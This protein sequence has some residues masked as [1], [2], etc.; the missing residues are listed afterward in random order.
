M[1]GR[2][3]HCVQ[4]AAVAASQVSQGP[5]LGVPTKDDGHSHLCQHPWEGGLEKA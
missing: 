1:V 3:R 5:G 2:A 4:L